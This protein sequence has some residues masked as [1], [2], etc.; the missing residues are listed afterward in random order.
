MENSPEYGIGEE[1]MLDTSVICNLCAGQC[2]Q[3]QDEWRCTAC[4]VRFRTLLGIPDMRVQTKTWI[5]VERDWELARKLA[6]N[7]HEDS[8][9]DL[10][11]KV[12]NERKNIPPEILKRRLHGIYMENRK[13]EDELTNEGWLGRLNLAGP[14]LEVGCGTGGFL[15]SLPI[16]MAAAGVDVSMAWLV[17]AK[18]RL[19]ESG[20]NAILICA[21]AEKLPFADGAFDAVAAF[22]VLEHVDG[23]A[24]VVEEI[25]RTTRTGGLFIGTT[26]NRYSLTAEPHVGLW[27]VG[28]LPRSLMARFVRWRNGMDYSNTRPQ[29]LLDLHRSLGK[30]FRTGVQAPEIWT[31]DL[32]QFGATKRR[33]AQ[34]YNRLLQSSVARIL[35]LPIVPFFR[36]VG[37]RR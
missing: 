5:H 31:G 6:A 2:R 4:G 29:S 24:P 10:V 33:I 16:G 37:H 34:V 9:E 12:W 8:F 20:R 28:L 23:V 19:E 30:W 14:L 13:H 21:C 32:Q 7:Y 22:D 1:P 26:P 11:A 35:L 17:T 27:G 15:V 36:V 25:A 18:K 3:E